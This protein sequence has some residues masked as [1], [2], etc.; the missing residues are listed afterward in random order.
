LTGIE[1]TTEKSAARQ[2]VTM[3]KHA[4]AMPAQVATAARPAAAEP[5]WPPAYQPDHS[6]FGLCAT[7][8][9]GKSAAFT[10]LSA[11]IHA[12][13]PTAH[14]ART[15]AATPSRNCK[16]IARKLTGSRNLSSLLQLIINC[17][18]GFVKIV[19]ESGMPN[20]SP[21]AEAIV[22]KAVKI[23]PATHARKRLLTTAPPTT[24][25]AEREPCR[26]KRVKLLNLESNQLGMRLSRSAKIGRKTP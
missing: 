22:P 12:K 13:Q 19:L 5:A 1:L 14:Q 3:K 18:T 17:E 23:R 20:N 6:N 21:A 4:A 7:A 10:L 16:S 15:I 26:S 24:K 25:S 2:S 8:G 9:F 11:T